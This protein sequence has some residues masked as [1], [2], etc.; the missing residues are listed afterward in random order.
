VSG[1]STYRRSAR[2]RARGSQPA[3]RQQLAAEYGRE[4]FRLQARRPR[5]GLNLPTVNLDSL[6]SVVEWGREGAVMRGSLTLNQPGL[7]Q[8]PSLVVKGD[9]IRMTVQASDGAPFRPLW[10]MT[11]V[12]PTQSIAAGQIE[13]ALRSRLEPAQRSRSNWRYRTDRQHRKGWDARQITLHACKRFRVKVGRLPSA[14]YRIPKLIDKSASVLEIVTQAWRKEREWTGRRFD[15]SIARGVLDVTE[16]HR[17]RYMLLMGQQLIDAVID[18]ALAAPFAS[19]LIVTSTVKRKGST[20]R[21]KLR[22]RVVDQ[23]R[24]RRYGYIV[25]HVNVERLD[26]VAELRAHGRR[27]LARRG[28]PFK[29]ATLTHPGIPWV[30]RG[31]GVRVAL[32]QEQLTA[33]V[34][35]VSASHR[36]DYGAAMS[37]SSSVGVNDPWSATSAPPACAAARRRGPRRKTPQRTHARDAPQAAKARVRGM[38]IGGREQ[39]SARN[40]SPRTA[41]VYAR[42]RRRAAAARL[43]RRRR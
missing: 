35:V 25:R 5:E 4:R 26:T 3:T 24:V 34:Y 14:K 38:I 22:V 17:P 29:T 37:W 8:I 10:E 19:A 33:V 1:R 36:V 13:L 9:I 43:R 21:R 31:A 32:P 2:G 7:R 40:L 39:S 20:R 11:V 41:C 28:S 42:R 30:D 15:V 18:D 6:V 12:T 27:L 23:A 16:L